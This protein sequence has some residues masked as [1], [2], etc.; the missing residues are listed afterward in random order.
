MAIIDHEHLMAQK[1]ATDETMPLRAIKPVADT[2][3]SVANF[4]KK[5]DEERGLNRDRLFR[6]D[7]AR[8]EVLEYRPPSERPETVIESHRKFRWAG[9]FPVRPVQTL[10]GRL[11]IPNPRMQDIPRDPKPEGVEQSGEDTATHALPAVEKLTGKPAVDKLAHR[12]AAHVQRV[13]NE[14]SW[15]IAVWYG[16]A[17][18]RYWVMDE[19]GLHEF[20]S[21]TTMYQGMGWEAL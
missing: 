16:E 9:P 13:F 4:G 12:S 2:P 6:E 21:I 15:P 5:T 20:E 19:T 11:S 17:T 18:R 1:G 8:S 3:G 7:I 10:G 14:A